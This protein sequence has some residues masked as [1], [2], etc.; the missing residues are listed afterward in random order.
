MTRRPLL[1]LLIGL[2]LASCAV[3]PR[4]A[5]PEPKGDV[6]RAQ[7]KAVVFEGT[8]VELFPSPRVWCELARDLAT[9][10]AVRYHVDR[11][12]DGDL[13]ARDVVVFYFLNRPAGCADCKPALAEKDFAAGTRHRVTAWRT[14]DGDL[15]SWPKAGD[16]QKR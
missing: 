11:V 4:A 2:V 16:F 8:V 13:G 9:F 7:G 1:G 3:H 5:T 10:Q 15:T 12:P 6:L 14:P